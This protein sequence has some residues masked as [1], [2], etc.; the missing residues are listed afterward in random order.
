MS[1]QMPVSAPI[2]ARPVT[3]GQIPTLLRAVRDFVNEEVDKLNRQNRTTLEAVRDFVNE[4]VGHDLDA[5][6]AQA[7]TVAL[8]SD[9]DIQ[10]SVQAAVDA[11]TALAT[12]TRAVLLHERAVNRDNTSAWLVKII[13]GESLL[14]E[15]E[16][17]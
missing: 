4:K 10:R 1:N 13:D 9:L 6:M 7:R 14:D 16:A 5:A 2:Y 17:A 12:E 15:L 8:A 11:N 3:E